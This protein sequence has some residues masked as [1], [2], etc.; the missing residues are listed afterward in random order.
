M[1]PTKLL[2]AGSRN[3]KQGSKGPKSPL[4]SSSQKK[5]QVTNSQF[6]SQNQSFLNSSREIEKHQLFEAGP[7]EQLKDNN[8]NRLTGE[9]Y[10]ISSSQPI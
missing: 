9:M 5:P 10:F 2:S 3:I 8:M 6:N 4:G 7:I 1:S